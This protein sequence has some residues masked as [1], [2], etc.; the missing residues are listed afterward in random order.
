[1]ASLRP[2]RDTFVSLC[3]RTQSHDSVRR[4]DR[5]ARSVLG[6]GGTPRFGSC[7]FPEVPRYSTTSSARRR[8][9]DGMTTP[10]ALADLRLM[11]SSNFVAPANR[12]VSHLSE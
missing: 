5:E 1:M 8:K 7:H 3:G 9:E 10:S 11:T 2:L 6:R 4:P 12:P